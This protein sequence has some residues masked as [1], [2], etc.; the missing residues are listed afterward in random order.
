MASQATKTDWP[1]TLY[2]N[3]RNSSTLKIV[4][5]PIPLSHQISVSWYIK[6]GWK[7]VIGDMREVAISAT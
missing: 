5:A 6:G 2:R 3:V 7:L 4:Q 1:C